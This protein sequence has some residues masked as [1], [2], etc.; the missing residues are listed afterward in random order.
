MAEID[1]KHEPTANAGL[2]KVDTLDTN[3]EG[4]TRV[5]TA[6]QKSKENADVVEAPAEEMEKAARPAIGPI[7]DESMLL[8][9]KKLALAHLG[10]LLAIFCVALDQT[11]VATALP[12]LASQF[13][14]LDELTWVV[15]A[16]FLTQ[17]G[18]ML[19]FGQVLTIAPAKWVMN[20]LIFGR[21]FQG[22][23]ASGMFISIL[24]ILSQITKLEQRPLLFGSFGGVFALASVAGP[25]MGGALT[26]HATWRWCFYIN[27]P[28][29]A[30]SVAAAFLFQPSNPPPPNPLY[31]GKTTAQ[32][33]LSLD[34]V[35]AFISVGMII[36]L[37][38]PLQWGG[39]TRPWNDKVVIILFVVFAVL[40]GAFLTWEFFQGERAMLPLGFFKNRTQVGGGIAIMLMMIPFL[41]ATY[42]LPF[43]Y[44]A[45]GRTASQ[46]GIDIIPFMLSAILASFVSGGIV[47]GT[48]H[49]LTYAPRRPARLY[50]SSKQLIGY[51]I[52]FGVGLGVAF[53][54]PL[55]AIQA[56]YADKPELIPQ[57]SSLLSFLQLI[58]GVIGIAI[59]GT[60]FNNKLNTELATYASGLPPETLELVKQSVTVIFM[61]PKEMQ[62]MVVHAYVKALDYVFI[63]DI[64]ACI[65]ATVAG[66]FVRNWNLKARG[67]GMAAGAV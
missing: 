55:M 3:G 4:I 37:L 66:A 24:T 51:Q 23:G 29:G 28:F 54:I 10:F 12:K 32:K 35:G 7:V 21:A 14:A 11:I 64:P 34:W 18:L 48:G 30:V 53:Q 67:G 43:F 19:A 58:G 42:Y 2:P 36:C 13:N 17:A 22:V 49:Y 5:N 60:I 8:T 45:K 65:L 33:W 50:M 61:L 26:D 20:V 46:S 16:Y 6:D 41:S 38:L 57:A 15:S 63:L 31:E 52:L 47:N 9:G 56:E 25:L 40:L 1:P 59:S 62:G 27:L 39:V 44:Q